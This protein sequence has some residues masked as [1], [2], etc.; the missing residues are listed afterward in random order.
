[1]NRLEVS[2]RMQIRE[3]M[4][5]GFKQQPAEIIKFAK[6]Q[7]TKT[8]RYDWFLSSDQTECEVRE[9]YEDSAGLSST[10]CMSAKRWIG[11]SR[12]SP[13]AMP[14]GST[15]TRHRSSSSWRTR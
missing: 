14:S 1:M 5:E 8:L 10:G 4:L 13:T 9:V 15:E 12:R 3:G 6:E 2:A 7:D 11:C